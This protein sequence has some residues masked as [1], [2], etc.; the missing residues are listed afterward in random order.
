M[1]PETTKIPPTSTKRIMRVADLPP[2]RDLAQYSVQHE[3]GLE[4]VYT[5]SKRQRQVIDL[6]IAGPVYCASPVRLSDV[7]HILKREIGIEVET[8]FYPGDKETGSGDYG[9][10]FLASNVRRVEM[11]EV[12]A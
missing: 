5:L 2:N 9:V 11:N 12:A 1:K 4:T 7:V 6:L 10:Y 8:R 3:D